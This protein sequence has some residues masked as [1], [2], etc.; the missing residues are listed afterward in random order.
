MTYTPLMLRVIEQVL[1]TQQTIDQG[2]GLS[3]VFQD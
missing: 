1:N 2:D 3:G